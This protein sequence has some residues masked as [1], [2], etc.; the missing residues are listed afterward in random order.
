VPWS[1]RASLKFPPPIVYEIRRKSALK[2]A[3]GASHP[4]V[5]FITDEIFASGRV[6]PVG[7]GV[8]FR[9]RF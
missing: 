8:G 1:F 5:T 9:Y 3:R 2:Q 6:M 4:R 7:N